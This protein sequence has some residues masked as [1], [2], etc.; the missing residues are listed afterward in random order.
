MSDPG[1]EA[2]GE[3]A[4]AAAAEAAAARAPLDA[5]FAPMALETPETSSDAR[6]AVAPAADASWRAGFHRGYAPGGYARGGTDLLR[7]LASASAYVPAPATGGD[8]ANLDARFARGAPSSAE[9]PTGARE[10]ARATQPSA[11]PEGW[12]DPSGDRVDVV[13]TN[14]Y[15]E[16]SGTHSIQAWASALLAASR[17]QTKPRTEKPRRRDAAR[18]RATARDVTDSPSHETRRTETPKRT[19]TQPAYTNVCVTRDMARRALRTPKVLAA[20]ARRAVAD[21]DSADAFVFDA[22]E[23][24]DATDAT[25]DRTCHVTDTARVDVDRYLRWRKRCSRCSLPPPTGSVTDAFRVSIAVGYQGDALRVAPEVLER[26]PSAWTAAPFEPVGS[27][28]KHVCSF[29]IAPSGIDSEA[30]LE[31]VVEIR[32]QYE[33]MRLGTMEAGA[34]QKND[35]VAR[36]RKRVVSRS[37]FST[38]EKH[39]AKIHAS[40]EVFAYDPVTNG[41][42]DEALARLV[43]VARAS[44]HTG[45]FLAYLAG[46]SAVVSSSAEDD[47]TSR[48]ATYAARARRGT[49][50]RRRDEI[51]ADFDFVALPRDRLGRRRCTPAFAR[52]RATSAFRVAAR[53][54]RK[55][56]RAPSS[57]GEGN[58]NDARSV[59]EI[60]AREPPVT[61]SRRSKT[62]RGRDVAFRQKTVTV[63]SRPR[64]SARTRSSPPKKIARWSSR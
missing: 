37:V 13:T 54:E 1:A 59:F 43:S 23:T 40:E 45:P 22:G 63:T 4:S 41:S 36:R 52:E 42:F 19:N 51:R 61:V 44:T 24:R 31:T 64:R 28:G 10:T 62:S 18:V 35:G 57:K 29:V 55:S 3:A 27:R 58:R 17:S 14:R 32:A 5:C 53:R 34:S 50:R 25:T 11:T 39:P 60:A 56:T 49:R 16:S 6:R 30:A 8:P 21:A 15:V 2:G 7:A 46:P 38:D 9:A 48:L 26:N 47:T 20:L 33:Q 12:T